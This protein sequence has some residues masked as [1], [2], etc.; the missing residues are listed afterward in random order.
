MIEYKNLKYKEYERQI[1]ATGSV[2]DLE[3]LL[4]GIAVHLGQSNLLLSTTFT[5]MAQYKSD[6]SQYTDGLPIQGTDFGRHRVSVMSDDDGT[7]FEP[8]ALMMTYFYNDAGE[9][10]HVRDNH[11]EEI[12]RTF[13]NV[14]KE[15]L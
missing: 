6:P 5:E 9:E 1:L 4:T 2:S 12:K 11:F 3:R 14:L 13:Q 8:Q 7:F 10:T 15:Y